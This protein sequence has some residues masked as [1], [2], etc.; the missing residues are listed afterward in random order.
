[1]CLFLFLNTLFKA[2]L[3]FVPQ[4]TLQI[5]VVGQLDWY[6]YLHSNSGTW[7]NFMVCICAGIA[8]GCTPQL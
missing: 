7:F 1:M 6:G 4:L 2:I 5:K 3:S 8:K